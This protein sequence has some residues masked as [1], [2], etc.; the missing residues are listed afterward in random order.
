MFIRK[1]KKRL[2]QTTIRKK[3]II[4]M[5]SLIVVAP[6]FL[7]GILMASY[8]YYGLESLFNDQIKNA[9][10]QT[11][12]VSEKYLK[13]H[14]ENIKYDILA[15]A[16]EIQVD[17]N[18]FL[19]LQNPKWFETLL[20]KQIELRGLADGIIFTN[21][22]V[23]AQTAQNYTFVPLN[24]PKAELR[25][26]T[27]GNV[28][29]L[30]NEQ[31]NRVRALIKLNKFLE[32]T[33][34]VVS[35]PIDPNISHYMQ[36]SRGSVTFYN[37]MMQNINAQKLKLALIF[38][39]SFLLIATIT[40]YYGVKLARIIAAPVNTLVEATKKI[41][42]GDYSIRVEEKDSRDEINILAKAFNLMTETIEKQ[43]D[44]L[45]QNNQLINERAI[46]IET[47]LAE[48]SSGVIMLDVEQNIVYINNY[49]LSLLDIKRAN[50]INKSYTKAMPDIADL[51]EHARDNPN[52]LSKDNL[53]INLL[54]RTINIMVS[55]GVIL[56]GTEISSYIITFDDVTDNMTAQRLSA[57]SDVAR[58]IAHEIKNPLTPID[59]AAQRLESKFAVQIT[60]NKTM[61]NKYINTITNN[62][63]VI[64]RIITDF[65]KFAKLPDP[66]IET[67]D[68][69]QI[70]NDVVFAQS[71]VYS[72]ITYNVK[73][74]LNTNSIM[75]LCDKTL[76][77][78][79]L[80]NL[81][82]N[83]A[84]SLEALEPAE[85]KKI[86]IAIV[87]NKYDIHIAVVDNGIGFPTNKIDI[88]TEPYVTTKTKGTGIGLAIVKK[89]IEDH[90]SKLIIKNL[91]EG[92]AKVSFKLELA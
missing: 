18:F 33:Y 2:S 91:K 41:R 3:I 38:V 5:F 69:I 29:I 35:R 90:N 36:Q 71:S 9:L 57:W 15:M 7:I 25:L 76:I 22:K 17:R 64:R 62:V 87:V 14:K 60:E 86:T 23:I 78:Q 19:L 85:D 59:L 11:V 56:K 1:F 84:E 42:A 43:R 4:M 92:G 13:E 49:A 39:F 34:L 32:D 45:L 68:I 70:I 58:R 80:T 89:I 67:H 79:V 55:I 75:V 73:M 10:N 26:A 21:H 37:S 65:I 82:K 54:D 74:P 24:I 20:R 40:M 28:I 30:E 6:T 16:N 51:L 8:Y 53:A 50:V 88:I 52:I 31:T 81:L 46:F 83:A 48:I 27:S 77:S 47:V 12:E 66:K 63:E 44:E 61:Y 72:D